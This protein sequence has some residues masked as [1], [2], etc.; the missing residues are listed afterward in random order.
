MSN[1]EKSII[2][3]MR[4][5]SRDQLL[6]PDEAEVYTP[7]DVKTKR[8]WRARATGKTYPAPPWDRETEHLKNVAKKK[9]LG[10]YKVNSPA[11]RIAIKE[12]WAEFDRANRVTM[13]DITAML[14]GFLEEERAFL[15][16][17]KI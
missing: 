17:N 1:E 16:H 5:N 15:A 9:G 13:D 4:V 11:Q 7:R 10:T 8:V 6:N 3:Y 14:W 2:C 12:W